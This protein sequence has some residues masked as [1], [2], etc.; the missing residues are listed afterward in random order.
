MSLK[1]VLFPLMLYAFFINQIY[2]YNNAPYKPLEGSI[3]YQ[4]MPFANSITVAL[5]FFVFACL[6]LLVFMQFGR[7]KQY[8][9][10]YLLCAVLLIGGVFVWTSL[11]L[12]NVGFLDMMYASTPPFVYL[13]ALAAFI[14]ADD[15]LYRLFLK[16][17]FIIGFFSIIM[18]LVSYIG[19]IA[20]YPDGILANS[21]V[22]VFYI[23]G[24]WLLCIW[25]FTAQKPNKYLVYVIV[26]LS[27]VLAIMFNSRSWI[28]Q[29][30]I[31]LIAYVYCADRR[32]GL[33]KLFK[34][35]VPIAI[36]LAIA[37]ATVSRFYPAVFESL[38]EKM[39]PQ[40]TRAAQY[41]DL[42]SQTVFW[43][44]VVGK[45]YDFTYYSTIQNGYY[46]YIDN[47][48]LLMLVRYGFMIGLT[49]PLMFIIPMFRSGRSKRIIPL[50]MWLLA[51]GGLSVYCVTTLDLKSVSLAI[52]AGRC[53]KKQADET[54]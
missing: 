26:A 31:W 33:I 49:Y 23:Q 6:L 50:V 18:S 19:F 3:S 28:I 25:S 52:L 37:I 11:T 40:E 9:A 53:I 45:G 29:S 24:F 43:D 20:K 38:V 22:L 14:G 10:G 1:K 21:S 13:T 41:T 46:S 12:S 39:S 51:L 8:S 5:K 27:I 47:A 17:G 34:T 7:K 54:V 35:V 36:I 48:Y 30:V 32:K 16:H 44:Y 2:S 42:F 4:Q 15:D